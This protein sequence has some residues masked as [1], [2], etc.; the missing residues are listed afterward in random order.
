MELLPQTGNPQQTQPCFWMLVVATGGLV[1]MAV[2]VP[3]VDPLATVVVVLPTVDPVATVVVVV[4]VVEA[5]VAA[6]VV[7]GE[8]VAAV[9][10]TLLGQTAAQVSPI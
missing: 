7:A 8:G 4:V 5:A 6:V 10:V 3:S 2:A 9:A 1:F